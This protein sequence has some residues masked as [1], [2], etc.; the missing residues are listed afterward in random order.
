VG[1]EAGWSDRLRRVELASAIVL[2]LLL[3]VVHVVV[4][5]H[6]GALWR[7]EVNAVNLATQPS[8]ARVWALSEYDSSPMLWPLVLRG[9]VGL[10][11]GA[12]DLGLRTLGFGVGV[13]LLAMLWW[14]ARQL[15]HAI[16]MVSLLL[17]AASPTTFLVGDSVRAYG[18]GLVLMLFTLTSIW[19]VVDEPRLGRI[20]MAS[21][22][23]LVSVHALYYNSV[24]LFVLG[25]GAVAVGLHRRAPRTVV[26]ML[27][28][29]ALAAVS[30][31]PYLV[32]MR[33]MKRWTGLVKV[34]IDMPWIATKF[35]EAVAGSGGF[36]IWLWGSLFVFALGVW[37]WHALSSD[38]NGSPTEK[39]LARFLGTTVVIGVVCYAWFLKVLGYP[40]QPWYYVTLMALLAVSFDAAT[41][42]AVRDSEW[43]RVVRVVAFVVVGVLIS[44][45]VWQAAHVR[46]TNVDL[47]A[48]RLE[49][50][51]TRDDLIVVYPWWP[52][53]TFA[54]YYKGP[55]PWV[56]LPD[57]PEH[58][59]H[60]YDAVKE[61]MLEPES[62]RPVLDRIVNTLRAGQRV[63]LVGQLGFL[64]PGEEPGY[65]APPP[66]GWLGWNETPYL[67][68]W[69]RQVAFLIQ[70][71]A[72]RI[73]QVAVPSGGP[74]SHYENLPLFVA[75]GWR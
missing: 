22:A 67:T 54:R 42:L 40:T 28:I 2:T 32:T 59:L 13:G 51:S 24:I 39:D 26:V 75:Q 18:C 58:D 44:G 23:A 60:R 27:G 71:R 69:S 37:C 65:L 4:L 56:T 19:R 73:S 41:H 30:M 63:W 66:Q 57:I 34:P 29:G 48:A 36:V 7:D 25:M 31:L 61:K 55:T 14:S 33:R 3:I 17:F 74:V 45:N 10:G 49:A 52:G 68:L 62:I 15:G 5:L 38:A 8:L 70:R 43:W 9:W 11:L 21:V 16:P 6:A 35:Y 46:R 64:S 20:A 47:L 53:M 1:A 72:E 50:L 12:T